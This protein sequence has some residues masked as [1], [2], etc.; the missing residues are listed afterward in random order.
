MTSRLPLLLTVVVA[1]ACASGG[2][3]PTAPP[4]QPPAV[5]TPPV[6]S[7]PTPPPPRPSEAAANWQLLDPIADRFPGISLERAQREL[8]AGKQPKRTVVVA[9][10]DGGVD[11]AH[12][13]LRANLWRNPKETAGNARD[14]D[15]NGLVDDVYG[16]N[17]IGGRDGR[18]VQWDTFEVTRL[19]SLCQK[20]APEAAS[21][22]CEKITADYQKRKG[23][24]EQTLGQINMIAP[25]FDQAVRLLK[26]TLGT[27]SPTIAKV[28]AMRAP[29]G[30]VEQAKAIYL[31]LASNGVTE[32]V[33]T[34]AREQFTTQLQ[35]NL[36]P[37]FNPRPIVGD[38]YADLTERRYGN[39]DVTG[40]DAKHGTHVAG[41]IGAVRGNNVG[42][43][44]VATSVR[45]MAVRAVP[46]GDERDKDI[47]NAIRYAV[48]QGANIINMSFGKAWSP[49]KPAVDDAA[50]YADSKGVLIVH[51][52]GND[53]EDLSTNPSYPVAKTA[54]GTRVA[55]WIEVGAS[56]WKGADT[57][58]A[59]F[60]NYGREQ[61]DVFA[62][63]EDILSTVPGG[64]TS[65]QSGTSMAA[66]VVS[67]LAALIMAYY[68]ELNAQE[69]KDI[70]LQSTTKLGD[71]TTL[72]PGED[73]AKVAFGTLSATGGIVNAFNALRAAEQA[74]AA[75]R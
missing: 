47:A 74:V 31:Q 38:N 62:P 19:Y 24:A 21:L 64:G 48:D 40:P 67:G 4:Q 46:D 2:T 26:Q 25:A 17:F 50:K 12:A 7:P 14:D 75:K 11:T 42:I 56:S 32:E 58:A 57:I 66:P 3:Q 33:I 35:Y 44:G 53:S 51:A 10:I 1:G 45:I 23:E 30:G 16:W 18:N 22:P 59:A 55:R 63:G 69:V 61:V 43:D 71:R 60:S 20:R 6:V 13:D 72:R 27:D 29:N 52:A 49:A 15:N 9:V 54:D 34:E 41:I 37:N 39:R 8:L 68:P 70:I 36:D 5:V 28:Q 65:R 73:S